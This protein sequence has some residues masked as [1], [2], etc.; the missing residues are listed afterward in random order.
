MPSLS[1]H[2]AQIGG[3]QVFPEIKI[4]LVRQV[5]LLPASSVRSEHEAYNAAQCAKIVDPF[6]LRLFLRV[7]SAKNPEYPQLELHG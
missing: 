6:C 4:T 7:W 1:R 3:F 2:G 5:R